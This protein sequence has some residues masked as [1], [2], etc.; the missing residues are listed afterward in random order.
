MEYI[1][2]SAKQNQANILVLLPMH[3]FDEAHIDIFFRRV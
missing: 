2:R 3:S 1:D